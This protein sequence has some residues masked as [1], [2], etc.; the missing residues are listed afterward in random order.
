MYG[1]PKLV[2]PATFDEVVTH[3]P[4]LDV[5]IKNL[6][7]GEADKQFLQELFLEIYRLALEDARRH[8]EEP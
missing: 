6:T 1:K 5:V 8:Y 3:F 4:V 7:C 2:P